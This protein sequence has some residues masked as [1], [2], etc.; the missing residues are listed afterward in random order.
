LFSYG[1][2]TSGPLLCQVCKLKYTMSENW[3]VENV[4]LTF[5]LE[6]MFLGHYSFVCE[7]IF[8]VSVDRTGS[9]L[10]QFY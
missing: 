4:I 2:T 10:S 1:A 3:D 9:V 5:S 8:K 6:F 7:L